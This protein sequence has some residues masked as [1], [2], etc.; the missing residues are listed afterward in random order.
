MIPNYSKMLVRGLRPFD[1]TKK[2][3]YDR[4]LNMTLEGQILVP[5]LEPYLTVQL[6]DSVAEMSYYPRGN[7]HCVHIHAPSQLPQFK[8]DRTV[9]ISAEDGLTLAG[10]LRE[11]TIGLGPDFSHARVTNLFVRCDG[12][13]YV[14]DFPFSF[15]RGYKVSRE[16]P[17]EPIPERLK[18]EKPL[19]ERLKRG[20]RA[21][22]GALIWHDRS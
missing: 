6:G 12:E 2:V 16:Q 13:R 14:V 3:D 22:L 17:K 4:L 5:V 21:N 7:C 9:K 20:F 8:V 11:Y 19:L 18:S 1:C 15:V 10:I